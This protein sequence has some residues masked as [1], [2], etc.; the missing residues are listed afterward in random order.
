MSFEPINSIFNV[1]NGA[2]GNNHQVIVKMVK[3]LD[4]ELMVRPEE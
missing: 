4:C 3:S 1:M 2:M